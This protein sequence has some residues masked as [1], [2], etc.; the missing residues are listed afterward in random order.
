MQ[1]NHVTKPLYMNWITEGG[2]VSYRIKCLR[3]PSLNGS[4]LLL[5]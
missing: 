4:P 1:H 2:P 5:D 3:K